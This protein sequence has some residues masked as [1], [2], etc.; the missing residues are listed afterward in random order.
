MTD[1]KMIQ[2]FNKIDDK[3]LKESEEV[4]EKE[5]NGRGRIILGAVC[6]AF[7]VAVLI[8]GVVLKLNRINNNQDNP[9]MVGTGDI[10]SLNALLL[11]EDNYP[12]ELNGKNIKDII[13]AW[14]EPDSTYG[15]E[16]I[17][18]IE[19]GEDTR[20]VAVAV[21]DD[22]VTSVCCSQ[23]LY[24]TICGDTS[25]AF[26]SYNE[27]DMKLAALIYCPKEDIFGNSFEPVRGDR[28]VFQ[29][30]GM[31]ME[32][33]P[34][35][36][37]LP[38]SF[39]KIGHLSEAEMEWWESASSF[40]EEI[41]D[42][43]K[44]EK[45]LPEENF[46]GRSWTVVGARQDDAG[47]YWK[48]Y[49]Q[50]LVTK[51][52]FELN[53]AMDKETEKVIVPIGTVLFAEATDREN[54]IYFES[55]DG[56]IAGWKYISKPQF[57]TSSNY[58]MTETLSAEAM[59]ATLFV[60]IPNGGIAYPVWYEGYIDNSRI[61][62]GKNGIIRKEFYTAEDVRSYVENNSW[63]KENSYEEKFKNIE[64]TLEQ[65]MLV[66]MYIYEVYDNTDGTRVMIDAYDEENGRIYYY[67]NYLKSNSEQNGRRLCFRILQTDTGNV[68][69][70]ETYLVESVYK[71]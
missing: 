17:W 14:G 9:Q 4:R 21:S 69:D 42:D 35:Q 61:D 25:Y 62:L 2:V 1:N 15:V 39:K 40:P 12:Q 67:V 16:Q 13:G 44:A 5:E 7:A 24:V 26:Y 28:Y 31:I 43:N 10:P 41:T 32:T 63:I 29:S 36:I 37:N 3:Y 45:L 57:D 59:L 66:C 58:Y 18:K 38:Y 65:N 56:R 50:S 33:Y 64:Q 60:D 11:A 27:D 48:H 46:F 54:W 70:G 49:N 6:A 52:E 71:Y 51:A 20:F 55:S 19:D 22:E 8:F 47:V 30:N 53:K 34:G 23:P 68:K